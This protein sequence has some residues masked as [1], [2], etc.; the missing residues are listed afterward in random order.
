M[1]FQWRMIKTYKSQ[2]S[3]LNINSVLLKSTIDALVIQFPT[4]LS[5]R[6]N[7]LSK[8]LF[9]FTLTYTLLTPV[10][11]IPSTSLILSIT[12]LCNHFLKVE[13]FSRLRFYK[14]FPRKTLFLLFRH[15]TDFIIFYF[16]TISNV[17]R[18][19]NL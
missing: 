2:Q 12:L 14:L 13:I 7:L 15:R 4:L 9:V 8:S 19:F 16:I 17:I 5:F 10:T 3:W 11:T 1:I 6:T 18:L